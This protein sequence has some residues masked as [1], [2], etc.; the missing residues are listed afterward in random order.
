MPIAGTSLMLMDPYVT[1]RSLSTPCALLAL[2]SVLEFLL[3]QFE[4][5]DGQTR[6]R[7][8]GVALCCGALALA[9]VMHPLMAAYAL[10]SVLLLGALLS[11]NRLVQIWGTVMLGLTGVAMAA[12]LQMS[13][14]PENEVYQRVLLTRD[15]WFLSQWHWYEW[16]GL[17][18]PLLIL[19][20]VAFR[21]RRDGDGARVGLARMAVA[22]GLTAA[23]VALLFARMGM[24]THQVARMQPLRIFQLVYVVM[25]LVL[26]AA[27]GE[28]ML[29][30]RPMRWVVAF[31]L[32]AGV[33]VVAER[34]TFPASKH[35]ELPDTLRWGRLTEAG[36]RFEQAFV[37]ISRNAPR[38]AIFALDA[39]YITRPGEDA[40]SFRAIAER[41]VLPDY[42]KDGG[43]VTNK[44]ELAAA[45]LQ[46]QV[47]QTK[48]NSESDARRIAALAPLG[49]TWVVLERTAAT[50]FVC[51]YAND[52][53]KV[54]QLP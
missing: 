42:S 12:G 47:A 54:C 24:A 46:G 40:Q 39:Q 33:M 3:P 36:N 29:R 34:R 28:R 21:W 20:R 8:R 18:A 16:I 26:G 5:E 19:S 2:V 6:H 35:L 11:S 52:A 50:G 15:Y 43:V 25:I 1:A 4:S 41:S 27:L 17:I 10:G 45:W 13:T 7:W 32:L 22:A 9:W 49:V 48:L 30:R 51:K 38:D 31:S 53:V 23:T 37:W 44:P 14:P